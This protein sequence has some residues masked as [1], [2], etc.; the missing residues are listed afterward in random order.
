MCCVKLSARMNINLFIC[1][2]GT[3]QFEIQLSTICHYAYRNSQLNIVEYF[4]IIQVFPVTY[5]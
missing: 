2:A 1:N 5:P 3:Q 4:G